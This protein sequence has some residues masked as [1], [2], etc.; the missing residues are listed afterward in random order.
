M[1]VRVM[2]GRIEFLVGLA[3]RSLGTPVLEPKVVTLAKHAHQEIDLGDFQFNLQQEF[4]FLFNFLP[5]SL[6]EIET[7][8]GVF[9]W[10]IVQFVE[11]SDDFSS[12]PLVYVLGASSAL[13]F[14]EGQLWRELESVGSLRKCRL[15]EMKQLIRLRKIS[16]EQYRYMN[17]VGESFLS[18]CKVHDWRSVD[19]DLHHVIDLLY[20]PQLSCA[21]KA[22]SEF[23]P[24]SLE[25]VLGEL[26]DV[27]VL[28]STIE[29]LGAERAANTLQMAV[30]SESWPL[31][32]CALRLSL[33]WSDSGPN[34]E[35]V[36]LWTH[37]LL[38]CS[39]SSEEWSKWVVV[40]N[41]Y[42]SRFPELQSAMGA[43]LCDMSKAG[44][45]QYFDA[46]ELSVAS[47]RADLKQTFERVGECC[48]KVR[49]NTIWTLAY[50]R[51]RTWDFG[52]A[53]LDKYV[54]SVQTSAL[55]FAVSMYYKDCLS[56]CERDSV[57]SMLRTE[58]NEIINAWY[59]SSSDYVSA[60]QRHISRFQPLGHAQH[61]LYKNDEWVEGLHLYQPD[62][63][64]QHLYWEIRNKL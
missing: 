16:L 37:L 63:I 12:A 51:W 20:D 42:P 43:A 28:L 1:E 5:L 56:E 40:F 9:Q 50:N 32:F 53:D 29:S 24:A 15:E 62:W 11:V 45:I 41:R 58:F 25:K 10:L 61:N 22:I 36:A 52:V 3:V 48:D 7:I 13:D 49:R 17:G 35:I 47:N 30:N 64:S 44:L 55:D 38:Q 57:E 39:E 54:F 14:G 59:E 23:S 60:I 31:K 27:A 33:N 4:P 46:V 19:Q 26:S 8:Y 6:T 34:E 18:G 2:E 21:V